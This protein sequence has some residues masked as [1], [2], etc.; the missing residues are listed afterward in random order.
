MSIYPCVFLRAY[1][2]YVYDCILVSFSGMVSPRWILWSRV[3]PLGRS[4]SIDWP[5][6]TIVG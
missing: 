1:T 3:A 6:G 2:V 4:S 5:R